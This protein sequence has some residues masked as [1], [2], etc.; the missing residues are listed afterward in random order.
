MKVL[1]NTYSMCNHDVSDMNNLIPQALGFK[2]AYQANLLCPCYNHYITYIVVKP[3]S[4][5]NIKSDGIKIVSIGVTM[6]EIKHFKY[7][8][9]ISY[10]KVIYEEVSRHNS[11]HV[12]ISWA[13][14]S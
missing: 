2:H 7:S 6:K 8:T 9:L 13:S 10:G 11:L 1:H 4:Q 3:K 12:G 14:N 5:L